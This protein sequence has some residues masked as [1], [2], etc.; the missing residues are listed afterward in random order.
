MQKLIL[1]LNDCQVL[2]G[3]K[4]EAYRKAWG[5]PHYG[6]DHWSSEDK[7]VWA[8]GSGEVMAAGFDNVYGGTAVVLYKSV[9]LRTGGV[10]DLVA[11]CYH[12]SGVYV[13]AG[14]AVTTATKIG[15]MGNTGQYTSGEHLHVEF[16]TD[17]KW[18]C[19]TIELENNS[20]IMK[21]GSGPDTTI[22]PAGVLYVKAS[23]PD[24]QSVSPNESYL[25]RGF[26]TA[27]DY[28]FPVLETPA[29]PDFE[30][31]YN[32]LL[33]MYEK[34]KADYQACY[35]DLAAEKQKR[36]ELLSEILALVEKY[37]N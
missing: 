1:P 10:I 36:K 23:A 19:Y 34:T 33:A 7:T 35:E 6:Q 29:Q 27:E 5:R 25:E 26:I 32:E 4:N 31:K 8:M 12:M 14:Q 3:Y 11:R 28:T 17:T 2:C 24:N 30:A 21:K 20:N 37:K 22:D 15:L 13:K 18:P 9:Y 16:D